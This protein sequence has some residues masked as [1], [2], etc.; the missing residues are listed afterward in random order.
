MNRPGTRFYWDG[1]INVVKTINNWG[2]G[3]I[4][5]YYQ[6]LGAGLFA[7]PAYKH[8]DLYADVANNPA[9]K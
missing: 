4:V 2:Q 8:A 6:D 3:F 1:S 9:P 7:I 5:G